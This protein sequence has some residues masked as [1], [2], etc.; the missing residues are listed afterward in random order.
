MVTVIRREFTVAIP[1]QRAWDHLAR[2]EQ[3]PSWAPHIMQIELQPPGQLEPQSTGV[4]H[5]TN[6]MK[7]SF[8]VREFNPPRNW[9]W[10]GRF[11][12]LAV[13]VVLARARQRGRCQWTPGGGVWRQGE[14]DQAGVATARR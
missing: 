11:L 8:G 13:I 5:L 12:W 10:V 7:P 6:A 2:I 4:I 3:W 9:I 1:L 14:G